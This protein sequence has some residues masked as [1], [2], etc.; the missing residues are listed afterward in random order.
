MPL[1]NVVA[2][3]A[4]SAATPGLRAHALSEHCPPGAVIGDTSAAWIRYADIGSKLAGLIPKDASIKHWREIHR[5]PVTCLYPAARTRPIVRST[6]DCS[7]RQTRFRAG[8]L[9]QVK[10]SLGKPL[11][12]TSPERTVLDLLCVVR[13]SAI[14]AALSAFQNDGVDL[15]A[16][17]QRLESMQRWRGR[18]QG[19]ATLEA[20][21]YWNG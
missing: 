10:S 20:F 2:R 11:L 5:G 15:N 12:V 8:D 1:T 6:M 18:L 3:V 4:D 16:V 21:R 14:F 9:Q 19:I 13:G 17:A 7:L